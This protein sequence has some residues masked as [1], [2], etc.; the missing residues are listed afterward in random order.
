MSSNVTLKRTVGLPGAI[1]LG[2]G[3]ILGT[4]VFVSLGLAVGIAG[5]WALPALCLA[6]LL[7]VCNALSSAQLAASH[8]VSGGTY[9]YGY[10]YLNPGFGFTAG[11][12]FLLAKSA[13]A[14]AAAIGLA[15]YVGVLMGWE[16]HYMN[17]AACLFALVMTVL[18]AGGLRRASFVNTVLVA[19]ALAA[20]VALIVAS[21]ISGAPTSSIDSLPAFTPQS[22]FEAAAFLFVAFTGYGRIATLG[23]E[24]SEPRRTIPR[25]IIVTLFVSALLYF[26]LLYAGLSVLGAPGFASVTVETSAPLQAIAAKLSVPG[27]S[28]LVTVGAIMAIAGV[29]LNLILGLSRVAFSMGREGDLPGVLGRVSRK[30]EP[31]VAVMSIGLFIAVLA[32]FGGLESVWGFSAFA[33]LCYYAITNLAALKLNA[34]DRLYPRF[35]SIL[36]LCGCL[37]LAIWIT[38]KIIVIC[39][40]IIAIGL[41]L[42][43]ILRAS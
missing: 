18:V 36:G 37:G 33:V 32:L 23:E 28:G 40:V 19:A 5:E 6:G 10:R 35:V 43:H 13:S 39:L 17:V 3:S 15:G 30:Q 26:G 38:P 31:L 12:C 9:A 22:V 8:P 25:A 21:V 42:R 11:L 41:G 20:L 7:A 1:F 29:L 4:G 24:V 34:H 2:L 27:L 14:A 16:G